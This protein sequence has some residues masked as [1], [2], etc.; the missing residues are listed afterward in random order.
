MV[1][2]LLIDFVQRAVKFDLNVVCHENAAG[3]AVFKQTPA[4]RSR[5]E[6][7]TII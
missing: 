5:V 6:K 1:H 4:S 2:V 3:E 7:W